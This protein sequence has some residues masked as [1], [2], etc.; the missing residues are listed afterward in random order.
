MA[1]SSG[2]VMSSPYNVVLLTTND[3]FGCC[4][5]NHLVNEVPGLRVVALARP[6][7]V[8]LKADLP[9][10]LDDY[11]F[12]NGAYCPNTYFPGLNRRDNPPGPA[13]TFEQRI[14]SS[15]LEEIPG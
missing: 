7:L 9:A 5:L 2:F 4:I 3:L 10:P 12:S 6:E 11:V 8:D 13:F 1:A 15:G 14:A